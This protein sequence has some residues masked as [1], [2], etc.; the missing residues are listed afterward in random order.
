DGHR[1]VESRTLRVQAQPHPEGVAFGTEGPW[2]QPIAYRL[3]L[4][5]RQ[6]YPSL[7]R[8]A[9]VKRDGEPP[10]TPREPAGRVARDT[11]CISGSHRHDAAR[12]TRVGAVQ[13]CDE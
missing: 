4:V 1:R 7:P 9:R 5:R 2:G 3:H 12:V 11:C 8:L 6:L 13:E 10:A